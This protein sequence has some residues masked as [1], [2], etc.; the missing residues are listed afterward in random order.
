[1]FCEIAM[2]V[3]NRTPYAHTFYMGY[4]NGWLSYLATRRAF[5]EGGY[6]TRTCPFTE[7]VEDDL[8]KVV[9][10]VLQGRVR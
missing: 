6:E 8:T 1:M 3:R 5:A 2:Q 10:S 7:E 9:V 4:A